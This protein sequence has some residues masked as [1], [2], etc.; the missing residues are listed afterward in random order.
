MLYACRSE[1]IWPC[2][3]SVSCLGEIPRFIASTSIG[4]PCSSDPVTAITSSPFS[5]RYLAK[6]SA[7]SRW[8][9]VPRCGTELTYGHAALTIHFPNHVFLPTIRYER[10]RFMVVERYNVCLLINVVLRKGNQQIGEIGILF[11]AGII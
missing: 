1:H 9:N 2:I 6:T 3:W 7:L 4:V 5:R 11:D 8:M 10:A